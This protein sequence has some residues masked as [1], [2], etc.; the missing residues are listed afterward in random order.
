MRLSHQGS[1]CWNKI[2][3]MQRLAHRIA[4]RRQECIGNTASDQQLVTQLRQTLQHGQL[5]RHF[6]APNNGNHR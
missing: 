3:L 2:G 4:R 6:R 5:S 1:R